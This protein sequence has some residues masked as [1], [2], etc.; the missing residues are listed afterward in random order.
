MRGLALGL[1]RASL[2]DARRLV[3]TARL[4]QQRARGAV[5]I[6]GSGMAGATCLGR[7]YR[8]KCLQ[9]ETQTG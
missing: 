9:D 5:R 1:F 2:M 4:R 3:V 6:H 7:L 8:G